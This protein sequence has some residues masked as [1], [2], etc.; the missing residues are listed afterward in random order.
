[1]VEGGKQ[2]LRN[3]HL[4]PLTIV[5]F[6][7]AILKRF[8]VLLVAYLI[9]GYLKNSLLVALIEFLSNASVLGASKVAISVEVG[10]T[11]G[12]IDGLKPLFH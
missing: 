12:K 2:A 7:I 5:F 9:D 1:L 8:E 4:N 10:W 6:I 3:D 11:V